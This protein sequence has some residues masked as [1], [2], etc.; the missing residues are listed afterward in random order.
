MKIK[1][2]GSKTGTHRSS[3]EVEESLARLRELSIIKM[4]MKERHNRKSITSK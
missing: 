4:S 1:Q 3:A 2:N